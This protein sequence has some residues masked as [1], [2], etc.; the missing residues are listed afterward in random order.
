MHI[1]VDVLSSAGW[2]PTSTVGAPG[3]HGAVTTGMHGCGVKT[4]IAADVAA[5]T[6]GF[7]GV[8]HIPKVGMLTMGRLS[9]IVAAGWPPTF[10][11]R[12]GKTVSEAIPGGTAKGHIIDAPLQTCWPIGRLL[13]RFSV[14]A[15]V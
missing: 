5:A 14:S 11:R 4:P 12:I 8:M 3:V 1:A 15:L 13:L 2:P 7:E 6:W 10:T 9:M